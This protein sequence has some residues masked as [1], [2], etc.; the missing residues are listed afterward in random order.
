MNNNNNYWQEDYI[1]QF[2][3][4]IQ[5]AIK[6][7]QDNDQTIKGGVYYGKRNNTSI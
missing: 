6:E 4:Q 5:Q 1:L 7:Q 3:T 2:N